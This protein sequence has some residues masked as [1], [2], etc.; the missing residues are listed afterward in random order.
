MVAAGAGMAVGA[1]VGKKLKRMQ[2]DA[3]EVELQNLHA[4]SDMAETRALRQQAVG[5]DDTDT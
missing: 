4:A 2:V 1:T 5:H 3:A